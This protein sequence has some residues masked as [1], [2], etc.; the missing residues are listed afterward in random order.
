[1]HLRSYLPLIEQG[2]FHPFLCFTYEFM[3]RK[4]Q[5]IDTH[6]HL[7][8]IDELGLG[9]LYVFLSNGTHGTF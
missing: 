3:E 4:I 2:T 6:F 7:N 5:H 1:M 9:Q 8:V